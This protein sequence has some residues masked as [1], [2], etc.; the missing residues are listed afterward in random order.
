MIIEMRTY[1]IKP[2]LRDAFLAI[3]RAQSMPAH[4]D[5]GMKIMGPFLSLDNAD[6]FFFMRGFPDLESRQPMRDTFYGSDL[7]KGALEQTLLPMLDKYEVVVIEADDDL[8]G[9]R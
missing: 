5:I 9:W 6:M 1:T 4:R 3:F 7:W 8:G 2:G